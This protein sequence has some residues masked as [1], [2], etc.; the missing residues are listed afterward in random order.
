MDLGLT[1]KVGVITG[2]SA[3]IGRSIASGL[4][5]EGASVAICARRPEPLAQT[6]AALVATGASVFAA[7]C[8]VSDPAALDA[9]LEAAKQRFGRIDVLICNASGFGVTDDEDGWAASLNVDVLASVRAARKVIPWMQ[10]T[11]GGSIQFVSSISGLEAGSPA[12]YA[13]AKAALISYAKT[14]AVNLGPQRIRVNTIAPGSIEFEGGRWANAR[15]NNAARYNT[16]LQS[17]PWGRLGT[18]EEVADVAV[19]LAS[20]RSRW[21]TGECI[22]V[23][24]GQHKGNR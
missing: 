5:A 15:A 22:C 19:F 20:D 4:A 23:D 11:G 12:P 14:L 21:I 13:A 3:G 18:A 1:G 7:P 16:V 2:A 17:I 24:G 8:D 6:E 9:F 10:A